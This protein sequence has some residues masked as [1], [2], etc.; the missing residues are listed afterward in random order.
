MADPTKGLLG[1]KGVFG[2][3]GSAGVLR[4][5]CVSEDC[6]IET[7]FQLM[8]N[9]CTGNAIFGRVDTVSLVCTA[10]YHSSAFHMC[11]I[12]LVCYFWMYFRYYFVACCREG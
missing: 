12:T 11:I 3:P 9:D 5:R 2:G 6:A 4:G 8:E 1:P 10:C 7:A